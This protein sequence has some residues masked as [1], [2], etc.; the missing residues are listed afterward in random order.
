LSCS[1]QDRASVSNRCERITK[2]ER[3]RERERRA[4]RFGSRR[5][6][7]YWRPRDA[8]TTAPTRFPLSAGASLSQRQAA[9]GNAFS[10]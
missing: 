3:E 5:T 4:Q 2:R 9:R 10:R 8:I 1:P 7:D 6:S